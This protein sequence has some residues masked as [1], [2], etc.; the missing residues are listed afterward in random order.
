MNLSPAVNEPLPPSD[1][2]EGEGWAVLLAW[3][4][5]LCKQSSA[6]YDPVAASLGF[7]Q[8][9]YYRVGHAAIVVIDRAGRCHYADFG[10]YHAPVGNGRVR[11]ATTD[12]D[13]AI[14]VL[15]TPP[16]TEALPKNLS[17][18]LRFLANN[19]SCHGDGPLYASAIRVDLSKTWRYIQGMQKT[20]FHRYGPFIQ[21]GTNCSRFVLGAALHGCRS[22]LTKVGL[23]IQGMVTPVPRLMVMSGIYC[24][25]YYPDEQRNTTSGQDPFALQ[26]ISLTS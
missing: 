10:R 23:W 1:C 15:A 11:T 14:P 12:H 16:D 18:I 3:P 8:K 9:G 2:M 22:M 19:P 24:G 26:P 25:R 21:P 5:T 7:S 13:L 17:T 4:Q 20:G 6:W